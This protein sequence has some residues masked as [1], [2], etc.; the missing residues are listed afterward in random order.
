MLLQSQDGE[1]ELLPALPDAWPDGSI[2][3][4]KARGN[5]EVT[6]DW[7]KGKLSKAIIKSNTGGNCRL[8]TPIPVKIVEVSSKITV[9]ANNNVLNAP[10]AIPAYQKA[11]NAKLPDITFNKGHL[12]EFTTQK[13]KTYTVIP[14]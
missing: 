6:I 14:R 3:G 11:D 1:I 7:K 8:R 12:I 2:K 5:F 4:I 13:G 9:G 10:P